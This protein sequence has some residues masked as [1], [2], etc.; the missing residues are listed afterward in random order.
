MRTV[1]DVTSAMILA[2]GLGTRLR[3]LT[4]ELPKPMVPVGDAPMVVQIQRHLAAHGMQ[5]VVM[6]THH[7]AGAFD[8]QIFPLPTL[9]S[10]EREILGTGGG[11][12]HARDLF[13]DGP[14][15]V[16]NGDILGAVDVSN[17]FDHHA[18]LDVAATWVIAPRPC[19]DGTVG[20]DKDGFVVRVR[21]FKNGIEAR[22]GDFLG[23]YVLSSIV[24][25]DLPVAGCV[26]ADVLGPKLASGEARIATI[27]HQGRWFD[28]GSPAQY[29]AANLGWLRDRDLSV[30]D[31]G[32][33]RAF[34]DNVRL[35]QCVLGRDVSIRGTGAIDRVVAWSGATVDA[36][37]SN[38]IITRH[39]TVRIEPAT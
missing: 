30:F 34:T 12:R 20:V 2:A 19:G 4:D 18:R 25:D 23:I 33:P 15:L 9:L 37:I 16:W 17:L 8:D 5:R 27:D 13:D 38:A 35:N 28:V 29:L 22:G 14:L 10:H 36:P 11:I 7:L 32:A 21:S 26:V 39:H 24:F 1:V 6:N 31:P 3:P